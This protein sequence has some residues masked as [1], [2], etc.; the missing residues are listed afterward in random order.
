MSTDDA[1]LRAA[2]QQVRRRA[3][4]V[5][6]AALALDVDQLR[7]SELPGLIAALQEALTDLQLL[8]AEQRVRRG[9]TAASEIV[10]VRVEWP[11]EQD[12]QDSEDQDEGAADWPPPEP[13]PRPWLDQK[14]GRRGTLPQ[15]RA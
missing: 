10:A 8:A 12:Q 9:S 1:T 13:E 14:R 7:E 5:R 15:P 4:L 3:N 6:D 11:A 2:L